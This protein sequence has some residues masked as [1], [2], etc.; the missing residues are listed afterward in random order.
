MK[1]WVKKHSSTELSLVKASLRGLI[2]P[3]LVLVYSYGI[4]MD[5]ILQARPHA[6]HRNTEIKHTVP[7]LWELQ[8][9][10]GKLTNA[11]KDVLSAEG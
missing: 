2:Y 6:G 3:Y 8:T 4:L 10:G 9:R 1:Q 11:Q 5:H 7:A